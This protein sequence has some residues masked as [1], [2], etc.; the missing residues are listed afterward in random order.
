MNTTYTADRVS[1]YDAHGNEM[2]LDWTDIRLIT[3]SADPDGECSVILDA[4]GGY[5]E[6]YTDSAGFSELAAEL[7]RRYQ[8]P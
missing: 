2:F 8:M 4:D 7:E 6:I 1:L 3:L 5:L